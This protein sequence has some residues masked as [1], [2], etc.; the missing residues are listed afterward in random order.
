ME[1]IGSVDSHIALTHLVWGKAT[2]HN[3]F[4]QKGR[5]YKLAETIV[6]H[7]TSYGNRKEPTKQ[8]FYFYLDSRFSSLKLMK[9]MNFHNF[10]FV[11]S[12]SSIMKPKTMMDHLKINTPLRHWRIIN[13]AKY[14]FRLMCHHIKKTKFLFLA[15]NFSSFRPIW[16]ERHRSKFPKKSYLTKQPEIIITYTKHMGYVDMFNKMVQKYW[17][18]TKYK[19]HNHAYTTFFVHACVHMA[20]IAS[21]HHFHLN[22]VDRNQ[23]LF[24]IRLLRRIK[25]QCFKQEERK[26]NIT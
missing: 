3:K 26:R 8:P 1:F 12:C 4:K 10:N 20:F 13:N 22:F 24:R 2:F 25:E 23:L 6:N 16:V 9:L 7:H 11:M 21:N 5:I 19:D 17:R 14:N 15:S 18:H